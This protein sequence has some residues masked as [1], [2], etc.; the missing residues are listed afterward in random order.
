MNTHQKRAALAAPLL[1]A[2]AAA[3][4]PMPGPYVPPSVTLASTT[5][6][7]VQ[8]T[9]DSFDSS[10]TTDGRYIA[11][12]SDATNLV[13]GDTNGVADV[14]VKDTQTGAV[15]GVSITGNGGSL[16]PSIAADG[17]AVAFESA[18]TN[19]VVGDTNATSDVFVTNLTTNVTIKVSG[20]GVTQGNDFSGFPSMSATGAKVAYQTYATNLVAGDS[21][22]TADIVVATVAG[23]SIA[24]ATT[25]L[26]NDYSASP[27]IS[28]DGT[29][30]AFQT[31]ATNLV[32]GDT[33]ATADVVVAAL[34]AGTVVR[35]TST[36]PNDL[37]D[38][39]SLNADG[40]KVAFQTY[41]TNLFA[42]DTNATAD[43]VVAS[44]GGVATP[45]TTTL[46]NDLSGQPSISADGT[47][48][49]FQSYATNLVAGDTNATA[50]VFT[51]SA[52]T[53]TFTAAALGNALSG[54]PAIS[55]D[56]TKAS[57]TSYATN[58][59]GGDTNGA[60]D[61]FKRDLTY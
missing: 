6:T 24:R 55:G 22:A 36:Q 32:A 39:P 51:A 5:A 21:N 13:A 3:C 2:V 47:K 16:H 12:T 33:N 26:P 52:G 18:A 38:A 9:A 61:I 29:K 56:G 14:F 58:L 41:A 25:A 37:S 11:F 15:K 23:A 27:S 10:I 60:G 34:P 57:F 48:V 28:G 49:A 17:S 46:G 4:A 1:A 42:G 53:A 35:A 44:V 50:D 7:S 19:L 31:Y 45:A 43:V 8:A 40:T 20:F 59:V 30:V 54:E